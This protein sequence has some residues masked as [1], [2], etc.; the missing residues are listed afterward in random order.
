M[1]KNICSVCKK[2]YD[3]K[4]ESGFNFNGSRWCRHDQSSLTSDIRFTKHEKKI[5]DKLPKGKVLAK[6]RD[7]TFICDAKKK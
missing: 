7:G 1:K 3:W 4:L 6:T 2:P 5:I